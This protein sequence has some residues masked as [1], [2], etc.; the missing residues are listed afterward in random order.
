MN[1]EPINDGSWGRCGRHRA[2][3]PLEILI[4]IIS[5]ARRDPLW[6]LMGEFI[7]EHSDLWNEAIGK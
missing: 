6:L 1:L 5:I 4:E 3:R 7:R 2:R